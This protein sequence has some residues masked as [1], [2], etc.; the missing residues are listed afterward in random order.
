MQ[1]VQLAIIVIIIILVILLIL[2]LNDD[3]KKGRRRH[4]RRHSNSDEL[5]NDPRA[6]ALCECVPASPPLLE[7]TPTLMMGFDEGGEEEFSPPFPSG[8]DTWNWPDVG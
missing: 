4:H 3:N 1:A 2:Y 8:P 7:S 5:P 6:C